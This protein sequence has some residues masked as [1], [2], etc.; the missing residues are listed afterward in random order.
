MPGQTPET[1]EKELLAEM[2]KLAKAPVTDVELQRARNQIESS[3]VFQDDSV[4]R[5]GS[6]LARFELLGGYAMKDK[7][8][9]R[10][11]AVT[12]ADIERVARTYFPEQH[13]NVG[14]LLPRQ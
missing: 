5:R 7:Y 8:L 11:R 1:L 6:L 10:I 13:K 2:A 12:A 3:F 14:V 4:H 9:E